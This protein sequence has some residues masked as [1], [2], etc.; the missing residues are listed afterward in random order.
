M[1]ATGYELKKYAAIDN[2]ANVG[3]MH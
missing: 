2:E 1:L 3:V